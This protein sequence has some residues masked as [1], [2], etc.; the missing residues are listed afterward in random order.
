MQLGRWC[1]E[2]TVG[3][4][5]LVEA[6]K[7]FSLAGAQGDATAQTELGKLRARLTPE[8]LKDAEG[9]VAKAGR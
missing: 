8:Q 7:W 1:A 6:Y 3:P 2:G 5:D 4:V 9:R